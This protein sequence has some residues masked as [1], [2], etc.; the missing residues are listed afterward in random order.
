M[1]KLLDVKTA[2]GTALSNATAE[3]LLGST[4]LVAGALQPGKVIKVRGSVR[5]TATNSTDTLNVKVRLGP[6]TLTGTVIFDATAVDV[7]DANVMVFDVEL[8]PRATLTDVVAVGFGTIEGA[9]GTVTARGAHV[10]VGSLNFAVAQ[11]IEVTG[12]W[13]V[14]SSSNSCQL[15]SLNVYECV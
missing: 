6:T 5:A 10:I 2:A 1:M 11:R 9:V 4:V 3:T 15:E 14:A 12:T 7:A 13:S 8:V